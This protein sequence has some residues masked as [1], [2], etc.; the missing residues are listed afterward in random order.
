MQA[1]DT[2]QPCKSTLGALVGVGIVAGF[3]SALVKSSVETV[4]PP[5]P[6]T[7]VQPRI[8]L[9]DM[10]GIDAASVNYVFNQTAVNWGG[11]GFHILFSLVIVV[12][13]AIRCR[14]ATFPK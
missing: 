5:R 3:V 7:A 1:S 13:Y 12:V 4:L 6:P 9:L 8:G 2:L 10:M 14:R 11:N